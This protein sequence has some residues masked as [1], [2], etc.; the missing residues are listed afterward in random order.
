M[1]E[2]SKAFKNAYP[3]KNIWVWS[4]RT[5]EEIECLEHGKELLSTID[6]L[7]DGK[8]EEDKKDLSLKFRG[9]SNQRILER[10]PL[11]VLSGCHTKL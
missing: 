11:R 9:S 8:F 2:L 7:I 6:F 4:G 10:M 1:T 5:L 3:D